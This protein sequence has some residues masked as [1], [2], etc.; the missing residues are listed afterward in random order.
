MAAPPG[1][2]G[3]AQAEAEACLSAPS[4]GR[5]AA[6]HISTKGLV[7]S[8][9]AAGGRGESLVYSRVYG[10]RARRQR[11]MCAATRHSSAGRGG[12]APGGPRA[13]S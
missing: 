11:G 1:S 12:A 10:R 2:L 5:A 7:P 13:V 8:A 3:P 4:G 9:R 6:R